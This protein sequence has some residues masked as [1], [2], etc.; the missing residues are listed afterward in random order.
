MLLGCYTKLY[1]KIINSNIISN[2]HE[3]DFYDYIFLTIT[4]L[5]LTSINLI[6]PFQKRLQGFL[7]CMLSLS[8]LL[9]C[10]KQPIHHYEG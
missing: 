3:E 5:F 6:I 9:D 1:I 7:K 2:I 10:K 8:G 4:Y